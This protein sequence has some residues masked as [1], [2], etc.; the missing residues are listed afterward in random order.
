MHIS[1]LYISRLVY[2]LTN[3]S[4]GFYQC[5]LDLPSFSE[6]LETQFFREE[7]TNVTGSQLLQATLTKF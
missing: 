2:V 5:I 4:Y 6:S 3:G 7:W 1:L